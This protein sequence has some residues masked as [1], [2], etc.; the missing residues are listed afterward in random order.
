LRDSAYDLASIWVRVDDRLI[1]GQV[2]VGW[3][4]H[5]R[6]AEIWVVDDLVLDDPYLQDALQLAAPAGVEVRVYGVE[7]AGVLLGSG[8]VSRLRGRETS[9][10]RCQASSRVRVGVA[11]ACEVLLLVRSPEVAWA[12]IEGGVPL[13]QVNVGNVSARPGSVRVFKNISLTPVQAEALDALAGRGVH[14]TF[15]LTPEDPQADWA[16]VRRRIVP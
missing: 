8:A 10:V 3:R 5:L 14:I 12:L 15:Q 9:N 16:V 1:H 6:Y 11:E 7:E 13:S 4:Q 2:T